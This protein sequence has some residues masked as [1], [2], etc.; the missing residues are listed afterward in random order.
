MNSGP[1]TRWSEPFFVFTGF[2]NPILLTQWINLL[3]GEKAEIDI[4]HF[5]SSRYSSSQY[6]SNKAATL[7]SPERPS[8]IAHGPRPLSASG[9]MG[10]TLPNHG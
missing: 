5:P 1:A 10:P 2:A 4:C 7:I 6:A 9:R 3:A 8:T